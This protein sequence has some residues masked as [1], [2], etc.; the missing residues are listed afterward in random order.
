MINFE[1]ALNY[2]LSIV[3]LS[4]LNADGTVR[5][6]SKNKLDSILMSKLDKKNADASKEKT[7][8]LLISWH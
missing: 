1:V 3:L 6:T 4:L 5:K 2:F 7:V 8:M